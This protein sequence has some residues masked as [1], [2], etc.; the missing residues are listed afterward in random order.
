MN[1]KNLYIF[2]EKF[3]LTYFALCILFSRSFVGIYFFNFRL[4]EYAIAFS[5]FFFI[6]SIYQ[7][8]ISNFS[9]TQRKI[10][11][12]ILIS[13]IITLF[14]TKELVG[15]SFSFL[16]PYTYKSSSYIWS[17]SFFVLGLYFSKIKLSNRGVLLLE[18]LLIANFIFAIYGLPEF[19]EN[20]FIN[21]SDKYELQKGSDLALNFIVINYLIQRKYTFTKYSFIFLSLNSSL[22][23]PLVLYR[24][25]SAFVSLLIYVLYEIFQI[26]KDKFLFSKLN[27]AVL[28][29]VFV[30]M[31]ISTILSQTKEVPEEVNAEVIARSYSGLAEY[32][33]KH[34]QEEL[35]FLYYQDG[36]IYSGDGNLNWRLDMW[37]DMIDDSFIEKKTIF[38]FGYNKKFK[39]F[40]VDN[41][42]F[43]NDRTGLDEKNE[44]L[45]NY[46][47]NI[48]SRGGFVQLF[49]FLFFYFNCIKYYKSSVKD[50]RI[51][52]YLFCT[53]FISSF[54]SS[55]ENS[56]FPLIFYYFLGNQFLKLK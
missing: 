6:F 14:T 43:G 53:L 47:L 10:F 51:I 25:R 7:N 45:H 20:F 15:I 21:N 37:Q 1:T 18:F 27:L 11:K 36:R 12:L 31:T 30:L 9:S 50:S 5:L 32:R 13:F 48:F 35:P 41:T 2:S 4:G 23:L 52:V 22:L 26:Y 56:H 19:I 46:F 29:P 17:L 40:Q 8:K 34:F 24:S 42:G 55:M 33:L 28:I 44:N 16:N 54:D 49:L 38:G 39:V 3:I